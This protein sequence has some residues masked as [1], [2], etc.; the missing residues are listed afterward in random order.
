MAAEQD[1]VAVVE[2]A[3]DA[4]V[5]LDFIACEPAKACSFNFFF[6]N[7][8]FNQTNDTYFKFSFFD[9][10]FLGGGSGGTWN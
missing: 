4:A 5:K 7:R 3:Q 9:P 8:V 1:L 2:P 6:L 10:C